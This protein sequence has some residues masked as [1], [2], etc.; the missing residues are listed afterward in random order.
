ML[1][2]TQWALLNPNTGIG[3]MNMTKRS[4]SWSRRFTSII[5]QILI[6]SLKE[7]QKT[8]HKYQYSWWEVQAEELHAAAD[9][10]DM[11]TIYDGLQIVRRPGSILIRNSDQS[12]LQDCEAPVRTLWQIPFQCRDGQIRKEDNIREGIWSTLNTARRLTQVIRQNGKLH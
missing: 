5:E 9:T 8:K 12:N 6:S 1:L 10:K 2:L 7:C 11:T 4:A 3:L